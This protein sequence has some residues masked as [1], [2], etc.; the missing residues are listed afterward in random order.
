M[1]V[2]APVVSSSEAVDWISNDGI[3]RFD[4]S[5]SNVKTLVGL[6]SIDVSDSVG[7]KLAIKRADTLLPYV[8]AI[9]SCK[10][11]RSHLRRG[12]TTAIRRVTP[13]STY[14]L[15]QFITSLSID[16]LSRS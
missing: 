3:A 15:K 6:N 16:S 4:W 1:G 2:L 8:G 7:E 10:A 12:S 9:F 14:L 5:T 13:I 11:A